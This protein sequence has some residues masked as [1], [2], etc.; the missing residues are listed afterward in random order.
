MRTKKQHG[1]VIL[2]SNKT[3][4]QRKVIKRQWKGHFILIKGKV[5]QDDLLIMNIY[6]SNERAPHS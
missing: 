5:D 2:I 1:T 6:S 3:V 4:F